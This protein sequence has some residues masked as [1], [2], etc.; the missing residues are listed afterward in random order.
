MIVGNR[1]STNLGVPSHDGCHNCKSLAFDVIIPS[2][3][4][5]VLDHVSLAAAFDCPAP[6][7]WPGCSVDDVPGPVT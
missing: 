3:Q 6:H 7:I 5:T 1:E 4:R 2:C